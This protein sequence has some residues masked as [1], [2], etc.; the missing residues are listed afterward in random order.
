[1]ASCDDH[2]T[3]IALPQSFRDGLESVVWPGRCQLIPIPDHLIDPQAAQPEQKDTTHRLSFFV[4]GAHTPASII[5]GL[6]TFVRQTEDQRL[7]ADAENILIFSCTHS[8]NPISLLGPL[9]SC[10]RFSKVLFCNVEDQQS[11]SSRKQLL[12]SFSEWLEG[13]EVLFLE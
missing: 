8:R 12:S 9:A 7:E 1:M 5:A 11:W 3:P 13:T 2:F 6:E 4:D 10:N